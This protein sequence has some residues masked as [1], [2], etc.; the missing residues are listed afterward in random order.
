MTMDLAEV[1][2]TNCD[3]E[4]IHI[5]G[6]I[7]PFG[8]LL[9]TS[10]DWIVQRAAN[11]APF[12]GKDTD[13][14][15]GETLTDI[16]M[17]FAIKQIRRRVVMLRTE[18]AVERIFSLQLREDDRKFD[19]AVHFSGDQLIIECE[20]AT[21]DE[22]E[23]SSTVRSMIQRIDGAPTL[24]ALL[25]DGARQCRMLTGFDRVMVYRFAESGS[26][27]VVAEALE[28]GIDSF[29]GLNF[30]ATDIPQQARRLYVRNT[31]RIICDVNEPSVAIEPRDQP[32]VDLSLSLL[33]AVSPIHIEYLK[34]MGVSASLSISIIVDGR[35]WGLF[36]CH[37][38][39]PRLPSFAERS[40]AE[41][42]GLMFSLVLERKLRA[43]EMAYEDEA[44]KVSNRL[45][46]A[47]ARDNDRLYDADWIGEIMLDAIPA[48]GVGVM[49]DGEV[50]ISGMTPS[51]EQFRQLI[52]A[53]NQNSKS[54]VITTT[55]ISEILDEAREYEGRAAGML[56]VPISRRPRDYVVM[57][58]AEQLRSV[59]WA[60]NAE[61]SVEY[62]PN[63]PRLTPRKSFEEWSELVRGEARPFTPA[64]IRI[65]NSL[66]T[67]L[68]EVVL[69]LTEAASE[70]RRQAGEQKNLLIAELNHRV[71]NIL[72]LIRALVGQTGRE[73]DD[74]HSF[75]RTLDSRIQSLARAHDQLTA[76][77]WG[78]AHLRDLITT[79]ASAYLHGQAERIEM[80]GPE[81]TIT[82][83]GFTVMALVVHELTTNSTKYGA[84]SDSGKVCVEWRIEDDGALLV[85]WVEKGGPAVMPPKRR[86]FGTTII[87][88]SIPHELGGD[89]EVHY[90]TAGL[91]AQFRIPARYVDN[92]EPSRQGPARPSY[93]SD[94]GRAN[95]AGKRILL[96]E[97]SALIALDAE[98]KLIDL[99]A[100][101]VVLAASNKAALRAIEADGIDI[102]MLDFN[103]GRET[104]TPTAERLRDAK[105]PFIF[106]SGYGG[107]D[108]VPVEFRGVPMV[109]KPYAADQILQGFAQLGSNDE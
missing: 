18:D 89:A 60:G 40:A 62:G 51:E 109:V 73:A 4:P 29:M 59:R 42:F 83:D 23:V 21:G 38:H 103:L 32:A 5:L 93:S 70:E 79:E 36:A 8:F 39:E 1:D 92:A 37:H 46:S 54:E 15:I 58:R 33:R 28:N 64:Q 27:E 108:T 3:R 104:S 100:S 61:K 65:A 53:L 30:P 12:L 86:G 47:A 6:A 22:L 44:R 98:D 68:L 91:E 69:R 99:G 66:R 19:V 87:C 14:L 50:S 90:R 105:I 11:T 20:P 26:G 41:L 101:E 67:T 81:V 95:I 85:D 2:L 97:D 72:A 13:A 35:L 84:L 31:F 102:A 94:A 34:N 71:R 57:F 49:V 56:A 75:T 63:G 9:A 77:Q 106:A 76:D 96:V 82:P 16:F 52:G 7:Q 43:E 88:D 80:V 55:R 74:I 107:E 48:D 78:P 45:M 17:P 10:A 24:N 25:R